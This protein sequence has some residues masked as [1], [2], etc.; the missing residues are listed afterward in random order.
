MANFTA[1]RTT[2]LLPDNTGKYRTSISIASCM[3]GEWPEKARKEHCKAQHLPTVA[4]SLT[5]EEYAAFEANP[6]T[7]YGYVD[8]AGDTETPFVPTEW[9]MMY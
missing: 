8:K 2:A 3:Y 7:R 1:F 9:K 5:Q 6:E 4:L